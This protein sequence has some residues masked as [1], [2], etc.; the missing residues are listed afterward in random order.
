ME[1]NEQHDWR[2]YRS[3]ELGEKNEQD[4][5]VVYETVAT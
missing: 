1:Y 2:I 4:D 3:L 5:C